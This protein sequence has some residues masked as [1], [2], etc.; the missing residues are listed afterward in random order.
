MTF[1]ITT[2]L[3]TLAWQLLDHEVSV[4][5]AGIL[6]GRETP[7][8]NDL[9]EGQF[10]GLIANMYIRG[11]NEDCI[12]IREDLREILL[13]I[14]GNR[15]ECREALTQPMRQMLIHENTHITP[16]NVEHDP[17]FV[18]YTSSIASTCRQLTEF[19]ARHRDFTQTVD[20]FRR[21]VL[22]QKSRLPSVP[23]ALTYLD[24]AAKRFGLHPAD[25]ALFAAHALASAPCGKYGDQPRP[26]LCRAYAAS[27]LAKLDR[28]QLIDDAALKRASLRVHNAL[29]QR[30]VD[31]SMDSTLLE[32][33]ASQ[34]APRGLDTY[35]QVNDWIESP[36]PIELLHFNLQDDHQY[37]DIDPAQAIHLS[38]TYIGLA[39]EDGTLSEDRAVWRAIHLAQESLQ[40]SGISIQ[41]SPSTCR[42]AY[43]FVANTARRAAHEEAARISA[44]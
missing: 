29:Q 23:S 17:F 7:C 3:E 9:D 34:M 14:T 16:N 25:A 33:L 31:G 11:I 26:V 44:A 15:A 36:D 13:H 38:Q 22:R 18:A 24:E 30:L 35:Q 41:M 43:K 28:L 5:S 20:M 40:K 10:A 12:W 21:E 39:I 8:W 42:L 19:L 37:Q 2:S 27:K 4:A 32:A 1:T 6:D